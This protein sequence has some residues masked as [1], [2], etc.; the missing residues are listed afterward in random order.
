MS[1]DML[2]HVSDDFVSLVAKRIPQSGTYV[3]GIWQSADGVAGDYDINL[4]PLND[5]ESKNYAQGRRLE[6][7]RKVFINDGELFGLQPSDIWEFDPGEGVQQFEIVSMDNRPWRN[8]CKL[9]LVRL[10]DQS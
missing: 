2:G 3:D 6:D 1:L 7:Y 5:R 8:Y 9:I 4:Q 10:D